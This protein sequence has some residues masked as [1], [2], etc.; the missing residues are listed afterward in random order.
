MSNLSKW[1]SIIIVILVVIGL[2]GALL[3]F[4]KSD[5]NVVSN[6]SV[7]ESSSASVQYTSDELLGEYTN[8]SAKINLS[9]MSVEEGAGV[10]ISGTTITVSSAGIYYFSGTTTEGNVVVNADNQE[11]VLVFDNVNISCKTTAVVNVIDAKKVTINIP[12][13]TTSTFTDSSQYTVFTEEDE[14]DA[15]IFSKDDLSIDG[16]GT[17]VINANYQDAIASKDGLK[18]VST[19]LKITAV[20]DAIRGKDY[21]AIKDAN[22]TIN[23][24]G[25]AIKVTEETDTSLGFI[26]IDGG[27]FN[28]ES[29]DD[30]LHSNN[31]IVIND[32]T[33]NI[34]AGDDGIHADS[35]IFINGG[36]MNIS[37]SYEGIE[38]NYIEING[39]EIS[40]VASDD[41]INVNGGTDTMGIMKQDDFKTVTENDSNNNQMLVING[42]NI[43][44]ESNGDGLDANGSIQINGGTTIVGGSTNGG[45]SALDYDKTFTISGGTLIAYGP[46]GMWQNPSNSSEQYTIVFETSGKA[47][48]K[49]ELKDANGNVIASYTANRAYGIICIST[50]DLKQGESYS[51]YVNDAEVGTQELTSIV[52]SNGSALG[53][54]GSKG[55]GQMPEFQVKDGEMPQE[56]ESG[57]NI[58]FLMKDGV[59]SQDMTNGERPQRPQRPV[60][61]ISGDR[62]R[63]RNGNTGRKKE[64]KQNMNQTEENTLNGN[65]I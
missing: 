64:M 23:S 50:E 48:D 16:K 9:S 53:A 1:I 7:I 22:I 35:S 19:T 28:I 36:V 27:T 58:S 45:N 33:F 29:E 46:T 57:N 25:K 32:G 26:V 44:V 14:P 8:Y 37:K 61:D 15:T 60:E 62:F 47:N 12:S 30:A 49:I 56:M 17:L 11:V 51:L 43:K 39:G 65:S 24:K 3:I 40:V 5:Q 41:G 52:T 42:G 54:F 20:D 10:N 55:R 63:E 21:V 34:V 13:G 59:N 6:N 31:M 18:V 4:Q 38:A 2:L